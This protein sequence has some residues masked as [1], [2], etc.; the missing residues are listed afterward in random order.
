M[1]DPLPRRPLDHHVE[2]LFAGLGLEDLPPRRSARRGIAR[3]ALLA[4]AAAA[5]V[6]VWL[7]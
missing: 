4:L 3:L 6:W 5:L 2:P 7:A 1:D